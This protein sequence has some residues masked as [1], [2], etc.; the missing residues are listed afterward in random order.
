MAK[1]KVVRRKNTK[2]QLTKKKLNPVEQHQADINARFEKEKAENEMVLD[3][4]NKVAPFVAAL[5]PKKREK[6][7]RLLY[8][9]FDGSCNGSSY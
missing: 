9:M 5:P 7:S 3:A 2:V 1:K 8:E 4:M 6:L